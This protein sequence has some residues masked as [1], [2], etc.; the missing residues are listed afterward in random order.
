MSNESPYTHFFQFFGQ[1]PEQ[2]VE[3]INAQAFRQMISLLTRPVEAAGRCLLLSAPRAGYGKSHLLSRLQNQLGGS[4]EF[5]LLQPA[6]GYRVD[7]ESAL[8]DVLAKFT[9]ILPGSGELTVLDVLAR[10]VLAIGLEPLVRSGDVPCQD[11]EFALSALNNRPLETFDFHHPTAA[12]AHWA[13]DNF[14]LLGP[15]LVVEIA[16]TLGAPMREVSFWVNVLFSYSVT[17]LDQPGRA[18]MLMTAA[19]SCAVVSM[20]ERLSTLLKMF[21]HSQRV[22]LVADELE[23]MSANAEAALRMANFLSTLRHGAGRVDVVISVNDDVWENAFLPRLS[24][25]LKDRLSEAEIRLSPLT[26]DQALLLLQRR[27]PAATDDQLS[28]LFVG[29]GDLFSRGVLRSAA[30]AWEVM[31][32]AREKA[33]CIKAHV[34]EPFVVEPLPYSSP[35]NFIWEST[36][37][38]ETQFEEWVDLPFPD[39]RMPVLNPQDEYFSKVSELVLPD[40]EEVATFSREKYGVRPLDGEIGTPRPQDGRPVFV[41]LPT[42]ESSVAK[43]S[44]LPFQ[45]EHQPVQLAMTNITGLAGYAFQQRDVIEQQLPALE[46]WWAERSAV[47][48]YNDV[49]AEN[50]DLPA[51]GDPGAPFFQNNINQSKPIAPTAET[52]IEPVAPSTFDFFAFQH[53]APQAPLAETSD[54]VWQDFLADQIAAPA[55][56]LESPDH[57]VVSDADFADGGARPRLDRRDESREAA[58]C[59]TLEIVERVPQETAPEFAVSEST[60]TTSHSIKSEI[61]RVEVLLNQFRERFDRP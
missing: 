46:P 36:Q 3:S 39:E 8:T 56:H 34:V 44:Y 30:A 33:E 47:D 12:I 59:K 50:S 20:T 37:P 32:A 45:S 15:R 28:A 17:P 31:H 49:V 10:K 53:E 35:Q 52:S 29:A 38:L 26:R 9:R 58:V 40:V 21:S 13:R 6:D 16:Q 19:A 24:D 25:G 4:H 7:A 42:K 55:K 43:A 27:D 22:V 57:S 11:R 60:T 2:T 61:D 5:V 51:F 54:T 23:G 18:G 14:E 41:A 48:M 1:Q